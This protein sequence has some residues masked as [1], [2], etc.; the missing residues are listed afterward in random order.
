MCWGGTGV[1]TWGYSDMYFFLI[2]I[3][4]NV[5]RL[6]I[7]AVLLDDMT[8]G[9]I[10]AF[11]KSKYVIDSA[12]ELFQRLNKLM[13]VQIPRALCAGDRDNGI[14][15]VT[16]NGSCTLELYNTEYTE[17]L[18]AMVIFMFKEQLGYLKGLEAQDNALQGD[19]ATDGSVSLSDEAQKKKGGRPKNKKTFC[20]VEHDKHKQDVLCRRE[21][22]SEWIGWYEAAVQSI[23]SMNKQHLDEMRNGITTLPPE[24][25]QGGES[26]G[27]QQ[28][29]VNPEKLARGKQLEKE[30]EM[31][32]RR[33]SKNVTKL[34][35]AADEESGVSSGVSS[36]SS[37][38]VSSQ[39]VNVAAHL[40]QLFEVDKDQCVALCTQIIKDG[41]G[42]E[43]V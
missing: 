5:E 21:A 23:S 32:R 37:G 1:E 36:I 19:G 24:D 39:P 30:L 40:K 31:Y 43:A 38:G 3:I 34:T 8:D 29:E 42:M 12:N 18:E 7:N 10:S 6:K 4:K 28:N 25:N 26:F 27:A 16:N 22:G 9:N 15:R 14:C 35:K 11:L 2:H 17:N 41:V 20:P 33:Q 13:F